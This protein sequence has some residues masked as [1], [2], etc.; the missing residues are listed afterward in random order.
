M[1]LTA[2]M[3]LSEPSFALAGPPQES[4]GFWQATVDSLAANIAVLNDEGVIVAVN[5]AW[6]DFATDNGAECA[7]GC[8]SRGLGIGADYLAVCEAASAT[9][10][11]AGEVHHA[12][13]DV[14]AG[15]S[16]GYRTEYPCHAP[17]QERWFSMR[18]APFD[19]AGTF[20]ALVVHQDITARWQAEH[21]VSEHASLLDAANA[22]LI[23]TDLEG[24]VT[25]WTAGAERLYGWS[26]AE[27]IG[28]SI[29]ELTVGPEDQELGAAILQTVLENGQW[30]GRF[31][32]RRRDG[33]QFPAYVRD[34]LLCEPDGQPRGFVGVSIDISE[35]VAME[36]ELRGTRD[37]LATVTRTMPDGLYVLD[38]E[39][40]LAF[41][42]EAAE[43]MLGWTRED[44][45]GEVM[46]DVTHSLREDGSP[47][48][49]EDSSDHSRA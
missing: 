17:D 3:N 41:I 45:I 37:F 32:V 19:G 40:R 38:Q 26:A 13:A 48:S 27:V 46:H 7:T 8:G 9:E 16:D 5:Q 35:R 22:A 47:L 2:R 28:R 33:T 39:G 34:T 14:L 44:L 20:G 30:E 25:H 6:A 36:Q 15:R 43:Q 11:L 1:S 31:E 4:A 42:N 21:A 24:L 18:V 49:I 10:P 12:I 29:S 23:A